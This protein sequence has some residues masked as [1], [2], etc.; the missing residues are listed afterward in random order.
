MGNKCT[1]TYT[2]TY[3]CH[4][5]CISVA[6]S[7]L[8]LQIFCA[9]LDLHQAVKEPFILSTYESLQMKK[10]VKMYTA[11]RMRK[12]LDD[13]HGVMYSTGA[14]VGDDPGPSKG[15]KTD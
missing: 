14:F 11:R 1:H 3:Y 12:G 13:N 5:T 15:S 2:H 7:F 6:D 10:L 4:G 9:M 8:N